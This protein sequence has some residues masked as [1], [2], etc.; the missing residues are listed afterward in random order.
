LGGER[1]QRGR[2]APDR[3]AGETAHVTEAE[4]A[5]RLQ[6]LL[7]ELEATLAALESADDSQ[8]AVDRLAE[9]ADLARDVQ[10]EIERL[11]R[12]TPDDAPA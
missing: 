6:D 4:S 9:M 11:R 1:A 10:G 8:A 2:P 7:A 12:D 5:H 3:R